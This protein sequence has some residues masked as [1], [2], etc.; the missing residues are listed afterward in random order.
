M[1]RSAMSLLVATFVFACSVGHAQ[2]AVHP[3]SLGLPG[4]NLNLYAVLKAF[5]ESPTLEE[6]E[7]KLNSEESRINNLDL[8]G[9]GNI[10]YITVSDK[11]DGDVHTIVLQVPVTKT[12]NQDV[13]VIVVDRSAENRVFI[14][15]V[16]DEAL[17]GKDYIVEPNYQSDPGVSEGETPNPGYQGRASGDDM[18]LD[19][20][21]VP[22]VRVTPAAVYQWPIIQYI[23]VPAYRP[24]I[25]PWHFGFYP[26]W[27]RP[28]R[29]FYWHYYWGY[30]Y[31]HYHFY[32]GHYRRWPMLR[33]PQVQARYFGSW[34]ATSPIVSDRW[35]VGAF[36]HTYSHPDLRKEG[37]AQYRVEK[38]RELRIQ[39]DRVRV[40]KESLRRSNRQERNGRIDPPVKKFDKS[41]G[42]VDKNPG[43]ISP[44]ARPGRGGK[45]PKSSGSQSERPRG[46]RERAK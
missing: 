16:G 29:P 34:R 3:D 40:Q 23:Y 28:W 4:D 13:A 31:H 43:G 39:R 8:D 9:D 42:T 27:W 5:Q 7:K 6:F 21:P 2:Q 12:E 10:D 41:P 26:A 24:W 45:E 11:V 33:Y 32:F 36:R 17:Y 25:S 19:G 20:T 46:T 35:R 37:V 18:L 38:R 22:V 14:Q 44:G 15:V 30:H 1:S